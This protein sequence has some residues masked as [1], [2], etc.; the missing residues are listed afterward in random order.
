MV[1]ILFGALIWRVTHPV[2]APVQYQTTQA[3]KG[4]LVTSVSAS[5]TISS[6]NSVAITTQ[7]TGVVGNIDVKNGERVNLG[8]KLADITSDRVSAQKQAAAWASYLSALDQL[9]NV[10]NDLNTLQETEF[11]TNQKF[12]SDAIARGLAAT[13]PTYIE[14]NASWKAAE[15]SYKN[16]QNVIAQAQAGVSSAWLSYEQ[17]SPVVTAPASGIITNLNL[18]PGQTIESNSGSQSL[19]TITLNPGQLQAVVNVSEIDV[20]GISIGQQAT[21]TLDAFPGKTFTGRVAAINPNGL[22]S[23]GVTSY[24]TTITLDTTNSHI[25]H[26]MAVSANIITKI[27]SGV[28][29]VPSEAVQT[30]NGQS[31]IRELKN[32]QVIQV[33]IVAWDSNDTETEITSGIKEGTSVI[34]GTT[35]PAGASGGTQGTSPFSGTRGGGFGRGVILRGGGGRGG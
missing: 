14:E 15:T 12:I 9:Q 27:D 10:Q 23:S 3:T 18:T 31:Y 34:I 5:G 6:G 13:D 24:P 35:A 17:I 4:T 22:V 29:T 1:A 26:N 32:N 20:T 25:Y 30:I 21:L 16:Q 19:G 8:D 11:S 28:I 7:A 33:Q 2:K